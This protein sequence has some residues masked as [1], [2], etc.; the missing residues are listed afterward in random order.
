MLVDET[1]WQ[2]LRSYLVV[3]TDFTKFLEVFR[4]LHDNYFRRRLHVSRLSQRFE[5]LSKQIT[6]AEKLLPKTRHRSPE[7]I[8][9][10]RLDNKNGETF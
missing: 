7:T 2:Q 1:K 9:L 6:L 10:I 4:F 8:N 3:W 5:E